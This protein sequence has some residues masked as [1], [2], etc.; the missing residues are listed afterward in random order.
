VLRNYAELAWCLYGSRRINCTTGPWVTHTLIYSERGVVRC[1][2]TLRNPSDP[3]VS[4]ANVNLARTVWHSHEGQTLH[5]KHEMCC[6]PVNIRIKFLYK[7]TN[8]NLHSFKPKP[9]ATTQK[10]EEFHFTLSCGKIR[11]EAFERRI[12]RKFYGPV[13]E[14]DTWRA[15]YNQEVCELHQELDVE[16]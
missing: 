4:Q 8:P 3:S 6:F 15:R 12:L 10:T 2:W 5:K 13:K 7:S 1:A 9:G 16:N 11:L 14:K